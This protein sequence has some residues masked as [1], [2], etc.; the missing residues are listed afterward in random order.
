MNGWMDKYYT[1]SKKK[2]DPEIHISY[3]HK[4]MKFLEKT[5]Y[6]ER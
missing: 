4:V 2:S 5:D 3:D 6:R 1:K